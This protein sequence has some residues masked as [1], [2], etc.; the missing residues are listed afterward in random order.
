[1]YLQV[2]A[3]ILLLKPIDGVSEPANP[4]RSYIRMKWRERYFY[5]YYSSLSLS[6]S[7]SFLPSYPTI[8]TR[9]R[10]LGVWCS[11]LMLPMIFISNFICTAHSLIVYVH[12]HLSSLFLVAD[13]NSWR[14]SG[15]RRCVCDYQQLSTDGFLLGH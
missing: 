12:V 4:F 11:G 5:F 14:S 6:L 2:T 3:T 15:V 8:L 10:L 1:M 13:G 7:I 9:H